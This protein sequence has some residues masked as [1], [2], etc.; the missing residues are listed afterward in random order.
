MTRRL[1]LIAALA[2]LLSGCGFALRGSVDL[3]DSLQQ[4]SVTGDDLLLVDELKSA[5]KTSGVTV[6]DAGDPSASQME[7][8]LSDYDREVR[9]TDSNGLATSYNLRYRVGY[10]VRTADGDE[11][12]VN[13]RLVQ[14]RVLDY[15]P[16]LELQSQEEEQ[17][18]REEM[19]EELI[20]Q[21]LRRLSRIQ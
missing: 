11:L 3:P 9:T 4:M 20:L 12:Q 6:V 5:L 19:R 18:L 8:T 10:D 14:K 1:L 16:L 2:S 13:Q 15:D 17:F 7:L 21:M